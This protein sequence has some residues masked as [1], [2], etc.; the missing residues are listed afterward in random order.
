[1][2][3]YGSSRN[4]ASHSLPQRALELTRLAARR[5]VRRKTRVL[6]LSKSAYEK[7]ERRRSI[8]A[9]A[10]QDL[11]TLVRLARAWA[12]KKYLHIPW[13]SITYAVAAIL[14]FIN[15]LDLLPDM[16]L[17][18][19]FVDDAAVVHTVVRSLHNDLEAFR[20]WEDREKAAGAPGPPAA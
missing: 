3:P 15:P 9:R 16:L 17:G 8:P 5:I 13:R 10:A 19:G 6:R 7:I 11:R 20:A 4:T 18:I 14:Y 2:T 12:L 1:M